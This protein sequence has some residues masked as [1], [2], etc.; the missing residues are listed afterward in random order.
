MMDAL[1]IRAA[2]MLERGV[3]TEE[4][5]ASII[6]ELRTAGDAQPVALSGNMESHAMQ[7]AKVI[8]G[9]F[10]YDKNSH[11]VSIIQ[12]AVHD[13]MKF[14]LAT[15]Q[16]ES[17]E[18]NGWRWRDTPPDYEPSPW[19]TSWIPKKPNIGLTHYELEPI[20]LR[21]PAAPSP[22]QP[23]SDDDIN[24]VWNAL[25]GIRIHNE[26]MRQ[27]MSTDY[28]IRIAFARAIIERAITGEKL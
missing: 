4:E 28:A 22:A 20:Y 21:P 26:A 11:Y 13:A 8:A 15:K 19:V 27:G 3:Y 23:L 12:C 9:I 14:S 25:P 7:V 1:H 5:L 16:H 18:P 17:G 2:D 6:A 24:A 10:N